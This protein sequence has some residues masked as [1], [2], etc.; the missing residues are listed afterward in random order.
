MLATMPWAVHDNVYDSSLP[1]PTV[2]AQNSQVASRIVKCID[3]LPN[4][5]ILA[6]SLCE[7]P[8]PDERP[9]GV[10]SQIPK[11]HVCEVFGCRV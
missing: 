8:G 3:D 5:V 2:I 11:T 6:G 9:K 7:W 4:V 10:H 1:E